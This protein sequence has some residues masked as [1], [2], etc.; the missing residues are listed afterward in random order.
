[1]A[2]G[3]LSKRAETAASKADV[4]KLMAQNTQLLHLLQRL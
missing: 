4:E 1:M 2:I 3:A